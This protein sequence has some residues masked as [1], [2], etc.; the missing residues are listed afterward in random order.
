[1]PIVSLTVL[2]TYCR[3]VDGIQNTDF[4]HARRTLQIPTAQLQW[5]EKRNSSVGHLRINENAQIS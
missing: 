3:L 4:T 5:S 2:M 1:M